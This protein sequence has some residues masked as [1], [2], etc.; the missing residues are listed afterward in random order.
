MAKKSKMFHLVTRTWN[1]VT[2]CR[3][4][5][6][7]CWARR[8]AE[9]KLKYMS[10]KYAR[11][12]EPTLHPWELDARF[13]PGEFVFVC[14]MG[15]LFG[16]WVPAEWIRAVLHVVER[17]PRTT[18]LFLTKNPKRYLQ[19]DFPGNCILG[20]TIETDDDELYRS[21]GISG[22]PPPGER[23]DAMI[24]LRHRRK[25]VSVEPVLAF[26]A[27]FPSK[28]TLIGPEI[29]YVGYDNYGCGLPEPP[30]S[31]TLWLIE[32]LERAGITVY[33]K[34]LREGDRG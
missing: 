23:I 9:E 20:A 28:I 19:F 33:R 25:L 7:Y 15:D 17:Y 16:W 5:C 29:V 31:D 4:N 18:F 10:R 26:T 6:V 11:G 27:E 3:H 34:T 32:S 8:L 13:G 12:F 2:G 1:P 14:D 24:N 22:A 21:Y 30:L